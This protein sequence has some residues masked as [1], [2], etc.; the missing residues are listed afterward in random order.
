MGAGMTIPA[1]FW[2]FFVG[3]KERTPYVAIFQIKL[4]AFLFVN[5]I[6]K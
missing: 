5:G 1:T 3:E 6:I 4:L 2:F